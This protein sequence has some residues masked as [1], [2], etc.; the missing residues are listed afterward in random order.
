MKRNNYYYRGRNFRS[1][2][3]LPRHNPIKISWSQFAKE[4]ENEGFSV[5]IIRSRPI[6]FF[7]VKSPGN[8]I[9]SRFFRQ[10]YCSV[11]DFSQALSI[12]LLKPS[13]SD[14]IIDVCAGL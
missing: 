13:P 5:N 12:L 14:R 9:K 2:I 3:P 11:Q 1:N 6:H 10:G 4:L 7:T 8:L